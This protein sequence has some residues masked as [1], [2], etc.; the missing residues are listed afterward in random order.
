M[1][2]HFLPIPIKKDLGRNRDHSIFL[3]LSLMLPDINKDYGGPTLVFLLE[4]LEN[5]RELYRQ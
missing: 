4:F 3:S 5:S 2:F 1:T